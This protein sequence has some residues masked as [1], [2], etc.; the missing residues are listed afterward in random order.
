MRCP[1]FPHQLGV[2]R[3]L[4]HFILQSRLADNLVHLV[5]LVAPWRSV[6]VCAAGH[7]SA[8]HRGGRRRVMG[9]FQRARRRSGSLRGWRAVALSLTVVLGE[10]VNDPIAATAIDPTNLLHRRR[11]SRPRPLPLVHARRPQ[12]QPPPIH[13]TPNPRLRPLLLPPCPPSLDLRKTPRRDR[14][15]HLDP[16]PRSAPGSASTGS[17][18]RG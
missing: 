12:L 10:N 4:G 17:V 18:P 1:V 3:C 11:K 15:L 9:T 2:H 8:L 14:R 13:Q 7:L 16:P 6:I 5:F